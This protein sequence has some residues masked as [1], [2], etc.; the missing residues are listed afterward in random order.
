MKDFRPI[1]KDLAHRKAITRRDV[2]QHCILRAIFSKGDTEAV[3]KHLLHKAFRPLNF[4]SRPYRAIEDTNATVGQYYFNSKLLGVPYANILET[5]DEEKEFNEL[6]NALRKPGKLLRNYS[7]F[8]TRQDIS[9]EQ[10][11]VQTAHVALELGNTLKPEQVQNLHFTCCGVANLEEL[12]MI[13]S[14]LDEFGHQYIAFREPDIGNQI[15]AIAVEP[16]AENKRGVLRNYP[17]LNFR[18]Q[19]EVSLVEELHQPLVQ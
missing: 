10:Q 19:E 5:V 17:L 13:Q 15:T 8:F 3:L 6:A 1:W 18:Q 11:L 14:V 9:P 2:I 4:D 12:E 7:Y 16:I